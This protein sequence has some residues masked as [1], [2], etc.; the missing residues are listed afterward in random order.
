[1]E[2]MALPGDTRQVER[3]CIASAAR[4]LSPVDKFAANTLR[5]CAPKK[6]ART[7]DYGFGLLECVLFPTVVYCRA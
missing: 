7:L 5:F 1:M 4:A 6:E 2:G 3:L